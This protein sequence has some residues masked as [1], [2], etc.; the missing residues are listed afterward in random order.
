MG[1]DEKLLNEL[2][3]KLKDPE[4]REYKE[5]MAMPN[6]PDWPQTLED[7]GLGHIGRQGDNA[8]N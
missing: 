3:E 8:N 7:I 2:L 6:N 1:M 4:S 5:L